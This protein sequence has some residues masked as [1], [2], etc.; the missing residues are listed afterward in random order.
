MQIWVSAVDMAG[1]GGAS[2]RLQDLD[3]SLDG[4]RPRGAGDHAAGDGL[5]SRAA[6]CERKDRDRRQGE[7]AGRARLASHGILLRGRDGV[8]E[9]PVHL[10]AHASWRK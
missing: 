8:D 10:C 2:P 5:G 9:R 1:I 3:A 6:G 7:R 4:L